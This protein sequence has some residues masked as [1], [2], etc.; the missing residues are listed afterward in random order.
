MT[1]VTRFEECVGCDYFTGVECVVPLEDDLDVET[2]FTGDI[3][4]PLERKLS[5]FKPKGEKDG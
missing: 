1:R 3:V 2:C 4:N 5:E